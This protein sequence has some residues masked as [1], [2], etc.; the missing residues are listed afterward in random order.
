M[1]ERKEM[2]PFCVKADPV[3]MSVLRVYLD[4]LCDM[5][6]VGFVSLVS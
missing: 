2:V 1:P 5:S 3:V 4:I 6:R